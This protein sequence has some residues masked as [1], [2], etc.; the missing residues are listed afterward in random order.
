MSSDSPD[1]FMKIYE[2]AANSRN[3]NNVKPLVAGNA[4]FWFSDGSYN[5][6]EE[7]R[8]AFERT[9]NAIAEEEYSISDL[10][11]LYRTEDSAA[12]IYNFRSRGI[13]NGNLNEFLGHGTNILGK[14]HGEWK[15]VHE[16]LSLVQ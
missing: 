3:F 10:Q 12:C 9:W 1:N 13:I 16:H 6:V 11:W 2:K 14:S 15:I 5:G 4:T 7:I 8:D